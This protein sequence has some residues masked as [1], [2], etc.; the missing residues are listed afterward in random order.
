M[1][2]PEI[3]KDG[4]CIYMMQDI[5][6]LTGY[7]RAKAIVNFCDKE[8]K[9]LEKE[10]DRVILEI[11]SRNGIDVPSNDKSVLKKAFA[12]LN[13]NGKE[14]IIENNMGI[15]MFRCDPIKTTKYFCI[16]LEDDRYLQT[17]VR[18]KERKLWIKS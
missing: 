12:Y 13:A 17:G 3:K 8:T 1:T 7:E 15:T 2:I 9:L 14:I 11:L 16:Y 18:V 5:G 10:V 4:D 6:G